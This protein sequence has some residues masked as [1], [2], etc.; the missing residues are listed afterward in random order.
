MEDERNELFAL[1]L[2]VRVIFINKIMKW[3]LNILDALHK[4]STIHNIPID[5]SVFHLSF[6][7]TI[8]IPT[9]SDTR[10]MGDSTR[11]TAQCSI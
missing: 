9:A 3:P 8:P 6:T 7:F 10:V 4:I 2:I 1:F 11:A 5:L